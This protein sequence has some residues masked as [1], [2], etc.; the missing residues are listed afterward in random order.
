MQLK[1]LYSL[2]KMTLPQILESVWVVFSLA[3]PSKVTVLVLL[4]V[5]PEM[6]DVESIYSWSSSGGSMREEHSLNG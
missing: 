4:L 2:S 5:F 6:I 3:E 1:M